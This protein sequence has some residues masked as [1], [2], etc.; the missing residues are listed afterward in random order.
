[1]ILVIAIVTPWRFFADFMVVDLKFTRTNEGKND[2]RIAGV[3][4]RESGNLQ[5][6]PANL[7]IIDNDRDVAFSMSTFSGK[8][9]FKPFLI[10]SRPSELSSEI[11]L[12][13]RNGRASKRVPISL[14]TVHLGKIYQFFQT[15]PL[16]WV[17]DFVMVSLIIELMIRHDKTAVVLPVVSVTENVMKVL[18]FYEKQT[19]I[20]LFPLPM[21]PFG[22]KLN[23]N[24]DFSW[25]AF[26]YRLALKLFGGADDEDFSQ[27]TQ[28]QVWIDTNERFPSKRRTWVFNDVAKSIYEG[29]ELEKNLWQKWDLSGEEINTV[30]RIF[31]NAKSTLSIIFAG[32]LPSRMK[33]N[34][35]WECH[36][37]ECSNWLEDCYEV[38]ITEDDWIF[39]QSNSNHWTVL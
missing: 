32:N 36:K 33:V 15:H 30:K 37:S 9:K 27:S 21:I 31:G 24:K 20:T 13:R 14:D 8:C 38:M 29:K 22:E 12:E 7:K 10:E 4:N 16:E 35:R 3:N 19:K 34:K 11:S 28:S 23:P 1:M 25:D 26:T 6:K 39:A 18:K 5:Q 2:L 17:D